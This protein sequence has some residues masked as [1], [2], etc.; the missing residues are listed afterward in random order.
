MSPHPATVVANK[1]DPWRRVWSWIDD[2]AGLSALRYPVPAH[3]N[4]ISYTLGGISFVGFLVLALTGFW[5][6]QFYDPMPDHV[7]GSMEA[8]QAQAPL[9]AFVRGIHFWVAN[10]VVVAV[11]LHMLRVLRHGVV[12][13]PA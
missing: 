9:G 10:I 5:L 7:R 12:Q 8:I 3:A 1:M 11:V 4:S 2:R 13:A 6:A